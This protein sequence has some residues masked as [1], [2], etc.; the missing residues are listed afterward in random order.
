MLTCIAYTPR[1]MSAR[2]FLH[3][4]TPDNST[5]EEWE[6]VYTTPTADNHISNTALAWAFN[7][8]QRMAAFAKCCETSPGVVTC[9]RDYRKEVPALAAQR[10]H[11]LLAYVT[12]Q[13]PNIDC[14]LWV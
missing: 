6:K 10:F 14:Q 8:A 1:A 12:L 7:P 13:Q 9:I 4:G 2:L 5:F 3:L 11:H